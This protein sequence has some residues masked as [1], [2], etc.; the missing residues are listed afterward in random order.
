VSH[1]FVL[2]LGHFQRLLVGSGLKIRH[3]RTKYEMMFRK[4]QKSQYILIIYCYM[5][6]ALFVSFTVSVFSANPIK[7]PSAPPERF[8]LLL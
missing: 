1:A 6:D 8:V 2:L 5:I 3:Y 4:G 7:S